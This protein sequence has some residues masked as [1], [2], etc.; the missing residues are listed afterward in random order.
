MRQALACTAAKGC[1]VE[2]AARWLILFCF[3]PST[4][5]PAGIIWGLPPWAAPLLTGSALVLVQRLLPFPHHVL[6][7]GRAPPTPSP[8]PFPL[9]PS[10]PLFSQVFLLFCSQ[11]IVCWQSPSCLGALVISIYWQL[12]L[13]MGF[14]PTWMVSVRLELALCL[15]QARSGGSHRCSADNIAPFS[16]L[17]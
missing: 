3:T 15:V 12:Q 17:T 16:L 2:E 4:Q 11:L 7:D 10:R 1:C 14:M 6:L 5:P 8:F 9:A 13:H